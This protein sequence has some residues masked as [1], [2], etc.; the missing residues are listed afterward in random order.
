MVGTNPQVWNMASHILFALVNPVIKLVFLQL[1]S[2]VT[3]FTSKQAV[4]SDQAFDVFQEFYQEIKLFLV[5]VT[6][7]Q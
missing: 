3:F 2:G 1:Y 7:L 5:V 4:S 6:K